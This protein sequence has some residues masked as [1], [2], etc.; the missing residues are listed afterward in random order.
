MPFDIVVAN[1]PYVRTAE[2][3]ALAGRAVSTTF[4]PRL[5]LDGGADGLAVIGRLL[6]Q[7]AWGLAVDGLAL[8]EIGGDQ[9]PAA[10][11]LA[12][13]RLSGWEAE[14]V[15]D[16]AGLPRVMLVRRRRG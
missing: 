5:A 12:D 7:L 2:L 1:L 13:E 15:P 11:A 14:T 10:L 16:L 4:E 8:L 6:D 9:G 3:D